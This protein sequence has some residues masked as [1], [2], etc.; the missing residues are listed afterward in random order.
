MTIFNPGRR[1]EVLISQGGPTQES[2][3]Q[4]K[5]STKKKKKTGSTASKQPPTNKVAPVPSQPTEPVLV[6]SQPTDHGTNVP[7]ERS[8]HM[9][10]AT[11]KIVD[12][13]KN[14]TEMPVNEPTR[15][16][17]KIARIMN[18]FKS[19]KGKGAG[20]VVHID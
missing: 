2:M 20:G 16:V 8:R 11:K 6:P 4:P 1:S 3:A 14:V 17:R 12:A 9:T 18:Q 15:P 19:A 7:T 13:K 10:R 5:K